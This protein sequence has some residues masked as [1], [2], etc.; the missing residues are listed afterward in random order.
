MTARTGSLITETVSFGNFSRAAFSSL[1]TSQVSF[2]NF[3]RAS[4]PSYV[5]Q[6]ASFYPLTQGRNGFWTPVLLAGG[7]TSYEIGATAGFTTGVGLGRTQQSLAFQDGVEE[8]YA[9]AFSLGV[10]AAP[11]SAAAAAITTPTVRPVSGRVVSFVGTSS[12]GVPLATLTPTWTTYKNAVTNTSQTSPTISNLGGGNYKFTPTGTNPAGIIDLGAAA[13]PRYLV[14][15][16]RTSVWVFGVFNSDGLPVT[17]LTPT[18]SALKKVSDGTDYSPQPAIS[19]L[20]SGLYKTTLLSERVTGV[21]DLGA[22][23]TPRYLAHDND[24]PT[25]LVPIPIP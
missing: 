20:G 7:L 4:F 8:G 21:L 9:E 13:S 22:T 25:I 11:K 3:S 19:E 15:A 16:P 2:G 24:R 12:D 1:I 23:T 10:G 17:G 18:W 5:P 6:T 14:Y